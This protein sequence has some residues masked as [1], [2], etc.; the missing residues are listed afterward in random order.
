MS[1]P[2]SSVGV[3]I[4]VWNRAHLVVRCLER[5]QSQTCRPRSVIIV[6]DGSTDSTAECVE[7]WIRD[8]GG[9]IGAVLL[10][11]ANQGASS[12][13]NAGL[14]A[15][16]DLQF[17][18]F[19]DSDD[20]WPPDF[21]E[22]TAAALAREP[23]AVAAM[24][25]RVHHDLRAESRT[26]DDMSLFARDP[27]KWMFDRDAGVGSST[28]FRT[29]AVRAAGGYPEQIATG[30][31]TVLFCRIA[32]LGSWLHCPGEPVTFLRNHTSASGHAG[33]LY[34]KYSDHHMRWAQVY[35][36]V[37]DELGSASLPSWFIRITLVRRWRIA[38]AHM[39][40]MGRH[41]EARACYARALRACP[42]SRDAWRDLLQSFSSP[43]T[44]S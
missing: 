38:G 17:V 14:A 3:V 4:P 21:L 8:N 40:Q 1:I 33:H 9:E 5:I 10:R 6:D 35:Q 31:D 22:R 27:I 18:A 42:W 34:E 36:S 41:G 37:A 39:S 2:D 13:R 29:S 24:T 19:L 23:G 25:D 30:H 28:V 7:T 32:R 15:M 44:T 26:F 20:L 11:Q 43:K 16:G 12:A